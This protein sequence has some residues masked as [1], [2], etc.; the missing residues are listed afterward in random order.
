MTGALGDLGVSPI[1]RG[2]AS[3]GIQSKIKKAKLRMAGD[4]DFGAHQVCDFRDP[5]KLLLVK[6]RDLHIVPKSC[7]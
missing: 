4:R 2:E 1:L 7:V 5:S 6:I 3:E